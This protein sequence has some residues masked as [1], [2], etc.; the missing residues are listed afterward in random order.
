MTLSD[1]ILPYLDPKTNL[2]RAADGETDN[3][4]LYT[5]ILIELLDNNTDRNTYVNLLD[6]FLQSKGVDIVPGLYYR[7]AGSSDNSVDNYIGS[8]FGSHRDYIGHYGY[9]HLWFFD[10]SGAHNLKYWFGRFI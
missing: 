4:L 7:Y 8:C 2:V 6:N 1:A 5:A 10:P 9:N 3:E